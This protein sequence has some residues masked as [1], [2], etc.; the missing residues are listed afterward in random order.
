MDVTKANFETVF[1]SLIKPAIEQ[2][3]F[4]AIDGEFSGL[5]QLKRGYFDSLQQRYVQ[6]AKACSNFQLIQWGVCAFKK[7]EKGYECL[8]FSFSMFPS[9]FGG[10]NRQFSVST[11]AFHFLAD[12]KF[13]FNKLVHDGKVYLLIICL[14][15]FFFNF[16]AF[17]SNN[18]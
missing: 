8:P 2:A 12:N 17:S 11:S 16:C 10:L 13:D 4:I 15:F 1:D 3:D 9:N 18:Y 5:G 14:F 7:T 6:A